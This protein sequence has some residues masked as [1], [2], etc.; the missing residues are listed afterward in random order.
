MLLKNKNAVIYGAGGSLGGAAAKAFAAAGARVFLTGRNIAAVQKIAGEIT[1]AGGNAEAA[2]VDGFDEKAIKQH[3]DAVTS[4]A[5]T[6]DISFN[7][8]GIDVVQGI[9]L[10]TMKITDF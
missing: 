9:A 10:T 1:A 4:N 8:V 7:A 3:L 5:G 2:E 6:V